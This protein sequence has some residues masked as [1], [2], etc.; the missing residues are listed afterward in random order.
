MKMN[1]ISLKD[2]NLADAVLQSS[3]NNYYYELLSNKS[4][5]NFYHLEKIDNNQPSEP[6]S[7]VVKI[8]P[9]GKTIY[10]NFEENIILDEKNFLNKKFITSDSLKN[11]KWN[12][13]NERKT[14]LDY[15]VIK[16]VSQIDSTKLITAWYAPKLPFKDGPY[17]YWGLPGIILELEILR[18]GESNDK[19][20]FLAVEI[21]ISEKKNKFKK[22]EKGDIISIEEYK[23]MVKEFRDKEINYFQDGVDTSN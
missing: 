11:Y 13:T 20:R 18:N 10:K 4:E 6:G 1:G 19:T 9:G 22:P 8:E 17:K 14:I 21:S 5:S 16:A 2:T 7:I 3:K 15:E 23:S 12:L